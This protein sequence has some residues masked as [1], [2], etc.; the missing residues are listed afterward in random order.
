MA[1]ST[2]PS[3]QQLL[4]YALSTSSSA[5]LGQAYNHTQGTCQDCHSCHTAVVSLL[6][7]IVPQ[8][9]QPWPP[10]WCSSLKALV[11]Q[12][13]VAQ[14]DFSH[15]LVD[16]QGIGEGLQSWHDAHGQVDSS[17]VGVY[18]EESQAESMRTVPHGPAIPVAFHKA[19]S[20]VANLVRS[21]QEKNEINVWC[22]G[23]VKASLSHMISAD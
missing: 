21:P 9:P 23:D 13:V 6:N 10:L 20:Q 5:C 18:P 8:P 1:P 17:L 11:T 7:P 16:M 19:N 4:R 2:W 14:V 15:A 3:G 22:P 12:I